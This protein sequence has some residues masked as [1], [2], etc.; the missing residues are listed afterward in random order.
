MKSNSS[1]RDPR[2]IVVRVLM[3]ADEFVRFSK[4]CQDDEVSHS[5]AL[6]MLVKQWVHLKDSAKSRAQE[7]A[8]HSHVLPRLSFGSRVNFG[9]APARLRP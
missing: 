9:T 5:G 7:W 1:K 4:Q 6:R 3:N 8:Q 2:V